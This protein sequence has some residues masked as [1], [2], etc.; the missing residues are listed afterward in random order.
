MG[1]PARGEVR[2]PILVL[3]VVDDQGRPEARHRVFCRKRESSVSLDTCAGCPRCDAIVA[4]GAPRVEC[5]F[6]ATAPRG[7][8]AVVGEALEGQT[9]AVRA[10]A[11]L[12]DA[13]AA[14]P[15]EG[16]RT[17][18][19]V[20]GAGRVA[21][22]VHEATRARTFAPS[23]ARVGE[24]AS[25]PL[26]V[27]ERTSVRDALRLLAARHLREVVVVDDGGAPLGVFRDLDG[28][29]VLREGGGPWG[30][31]DAP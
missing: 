6:D 14:L 9:V 3:E 25:T 17:V 24:L 22:V 30:G 15:A 13:V 28:F 21:G 12:R 16:H 11:P 5:T 27:H 10:D 2:H 26:T 18:V 19:V 23:G 8:D 7:P 1:G 31:G 20:D 29:R 4:G